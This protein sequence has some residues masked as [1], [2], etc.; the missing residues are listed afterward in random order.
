MLLFLSFT[1]LTL[2]L[3]GQDTAQYRSMRLEKRADYL[4]AEPTIIRVTEYLLN[5]AINKD[6]QTRLDAAQFLLKWMEGTP[7]H[8]YSFHSRISQI[9][10]NN[11]DLMGVYLAA[12]VKYS[13]E[14]KEEATDLKVLQLNTLKTLLTYVANADNG[15]KSNAE[16]K[17]L[18]DLAAKGQLER[19][20]R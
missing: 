12:M 14:Y 8:T 6:E 11:I 9:T 5:T 13:L 15:V 18:N 7:D 17:K 16:L 20:I 19:Y 2:T 3:K 10:K 1:V 4:N